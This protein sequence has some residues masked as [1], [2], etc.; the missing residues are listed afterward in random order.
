SPTV[1]EGETAEVVL[2]APAVATSPVTNTT[3]DTGPLA[4]P[5]A[6][7]SQASVVPWI[8]GGAGVASLAVSGVFF[9]LRQSAQSDLDSG[10]RGSV[11]PKSL[12]GKQ[13]D[14]KLFTTLSL[15]TLGVGIAG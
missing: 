10:C 9:G 1:K 15:V 7:K 8:V 2:D 14:G 5:P 13:D 4:P 3:A 12:Q 6:K 11:C